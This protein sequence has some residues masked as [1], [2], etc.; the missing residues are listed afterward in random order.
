MRRAQSRGCGGP[1]LSRRRHRHR[2][3]CCVD[4]ENTGSY[5]NDVG[6]GL[7]A[8]VYDGYNE[9]TNTGITVANGAYFKVG[10]D[11]SI[12]QSYQGNCAGGS[13][14]VSAGGSVTAAGL[15]MGYGGGGTNVLTIDGEGSFAD[16]SSKI[17]VGQAAAATGTI[18]L[19]GGVLSV[20]NLI[21]GNGI[22]IFN[23]G[24]GTLRA[25]DADFSTNV[26]MN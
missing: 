12:V 18:N 22:A 7:T 20:D 10:G 5:N 4:I 8:I 16:F 9:W 13:L 26:P 1:N 17:V 21:A 23:F 25:R 24:G 2:R 19:T 3:R 11:R 15:A 14:T 6:N